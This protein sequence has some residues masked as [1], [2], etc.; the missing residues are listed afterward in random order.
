MK[1]IQAEL[2]KISKLLRYKKAVGNK[3]IDT[4]NADDDLKNMK[5]SSQDLKI[6]GKEMGELIDK[7][8][9]IIEKGDFSTDN[10]KMIGKAIS[11]VK[12]TLSRLEKFFKKLEKRK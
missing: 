4:P 2:N 9:V 7:N 11:N 12:P 1:Q 3:I 10:V 6:Q 8:R 5:F